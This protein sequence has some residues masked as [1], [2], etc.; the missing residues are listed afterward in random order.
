MP[1][2]TDAEVTEVLSRGDLRPLGRIAESSNHAVLC[3]VVLGERTVLAVHKPARLERHLWDYPPGTLTGRERA[4]YLL[5]SAG[6]FGV[7]PATVLR[8]DGPWGPGSVQAWVGDPA[9]PPELVVDVVRVDAVPAGWL[10]VVEGDSPYGHRVLVA[11]S[12]EPAVRTTAVFDALLNNSDRKGG[13]LVRDGDAVRGFDHGV[14]LG[15]EPKLRTVLWGWAGRPLPDSDL[16]RVERVR[17][18]LDRRGGPLGELEELLDREEREALRRRADRL[19]AA[20]RHPRPRA[21]WPSIPW[22]AM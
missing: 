11:H 17:G 12:G 6:G 20:R 2:G 18:E 15:V 7:V 5:C 1:T 16:E 13:H 9:E 22:P 21:G 8:D 14:S 10:A 4:A 19:L 3:E